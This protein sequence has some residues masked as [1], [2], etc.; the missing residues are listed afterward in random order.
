M[1]RFFCPACFATLASPVSRCPACGCDPADWSKRHTY[2]E[3][4]IH[5]LSHPIREV[6]MAAV[7]SLGNRGDSAA[8]MPL[9]R[10]ALEH[11]T[12]IVLAREI[13]AALRKLRRGPERE[14]AAKLLEGHP[15]AAVRKAAAELRGR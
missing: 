10:C 3:R 15:A 2:R 6:Q 13:V 11:P 7:I 1:I 9:A 14:S 8:A 4:L 5:G 12:D